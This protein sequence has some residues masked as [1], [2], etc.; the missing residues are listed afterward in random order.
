MRP[1]TSAP[2]F[3]GVLDSVGCIRMLKTPA[4]Y[5]PHISVKSA[6]PDLPARLAHAFGGRVRQ[7]KSGKFIWSRSHRMALDLLLDLRPFMHRKID[8]RAFE[9]V[10]GHVGTKRVAGIRQVRLMED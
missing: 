6:A 2:Y 7:E 9:W 8:P 5:V 4:G 10:P 3:A 1:G